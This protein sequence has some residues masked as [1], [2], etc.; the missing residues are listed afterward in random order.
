MTFLLFVFIFILRLFFFFICYFNVSK[1]YSEKQAMVSGITEFETISQCWGQTLTI[2]D[3]VL[4][5]RTVPVQLGHHTRQSWKA[6]KNS[7]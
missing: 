3:D 4:L 1:L 5:E 7:E 6:W 2:S